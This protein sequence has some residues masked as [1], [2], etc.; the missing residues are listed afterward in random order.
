M[1]HWL[2]FHCGSPRCCGDTVC[3]NKDS[4]E[5]GLVAA[6]LCNVCEK[7]HFFQFQQ[8]EKNL[9][10]YCP[11][12][13]PYVGEEVVSGKVEPC[14]PAVYQERNE[15]LEVCSHLYS[16]VHKLTCL[17]HMWVIC[18]IVTVTLCFIFQNKIMKNDV[19]T[20]DICFPFLCF[21][22]AGSI[23]QRYSVPSIHIS[24]IS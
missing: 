11:Q 6:T 14:S 23:W 10:V 4:V 7:G 19:I 1:S 5:T 22:T 8:W 12:L 2:L 3:A 16:S 18:E 21:R 9:C 20:S 17:F 24:M 15:V 13:L